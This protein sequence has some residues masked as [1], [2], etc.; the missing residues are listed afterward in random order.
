[1]RRSGEKRSS[2]PK[3]KK[4]A[5]AP[6]YFEIR[7]RLARADYERGQPYFEAREG[8]NKFV[9]EAVLEKINRAEA[10]DRNSRLRKLLTD[11]SLLLPV[12]SHLHETGKLNFLFGK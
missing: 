9:L 2:T 8:L 10:N 7:I 11:E 12:L 4:K 5:V 6:R 3:E 1:M